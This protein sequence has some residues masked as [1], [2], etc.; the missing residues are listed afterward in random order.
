MY[1]APIVSAA[2]SHR[3]LVLPINED[4]VIARDDLGL[5]AVA[6]GIGG[7][8]K[9]RW[10]S[11]L[12]CDILV[13]RA[14]RSRDRGPAMD[15][16]IAEG[17]REIVGAAV[18]NHIRIG[19]TLAAVQID[20]GRISGVWVG[21]S[22]IYRLRGGQLQRLSRDHSFVQDLLDRGAIA[23]HEA[24]DHPLKNILHR[25]VGATRTIEADSFVDDTQAGDVYLLCSDGLSSL[26]SDEEIAERLEAHPAAA[27]D[28]LLVDALSA[29]APDNVS[30]V[31]VAIQAPAFQA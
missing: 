12:L 25:A 9:G 3:G 13:E 20:Q 30:F 1:H 27:A 23:Q 15:A 17:N 11:H 10:A 31:V 29:G 22:R 4:A 2:R 16:G 21:D 14:E 8:Q 24:R 7:E 6:D 28:M 18:R 26:L 5:W 19:T